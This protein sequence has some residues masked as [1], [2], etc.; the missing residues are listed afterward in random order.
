MKAL[1]VLNTIGIILLIIWAV[2]FFL[3]LFGAF[4]YVFLVLAVIVFALR[5]L[6]VKI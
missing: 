6:G 4:I 2:G 5:L 3:H 1:G